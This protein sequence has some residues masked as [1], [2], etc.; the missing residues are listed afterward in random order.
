MSRRRMKLTDARTRDELIR[1]DFAEPDGS[2]EDG[3][4]VIELDGGE[5]KLLAFRPEKRAIDFGCREPRHED[6]SG[7]KWKRLLGMKPRD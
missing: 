6:T 7:A 4:Y 5:A 1:D 3:Q 2:L